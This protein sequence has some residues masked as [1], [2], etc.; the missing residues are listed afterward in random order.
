[1][2]SWEQISVAGFFVLLITLWLTRD[3]Y[4]VKG[5]G[6]LFDSE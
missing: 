4:Y 1:M 2:L 3:L 6:A 5:W